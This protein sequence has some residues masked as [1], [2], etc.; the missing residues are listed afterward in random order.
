M[1]KTRGWALF[2]ILSGIGLS[3]LWACSL[4]RKVPGG[5]VDFQAVYLA[6]QTLIRHHNPYSVAE[7]A[8]TFSAMGGD[9]LHFPDPYYYRQLLI[10]FVN[11]PTT[12]LVVAPLA[13]L[14]MATAQALWMI[15]EIASLALAAFL[16][17]DLGAARAPVLCACLAGFLMLNC[18][19]VLAAGN[20]AALVI[21]LSV[22]AAWCFFEE[23]FVAAGVVCMALAL[24]IKP[25]DSGFVWLFF[26]LAGG[27]LR[28]RALQSAV[29]AACVAIPALL[30]VGHVAPTWLHDWQS[31]LAVISAPGALNDPRPTSVTANSSAAVIGLQATFSI[32]DSNAQFF[33]LASYLVCAPLVIVWIVTTLRA[34]LDREKF[35]FAL[36]AIV[37]VTLLITYHRVYDAKLL[38]L[39]IPACAVLWNSAGRIRWVA[40]LLSWVALVINSDV[41][42]T[43]IHILADYL[44]L[45]TAT[46][47]GKI[48]TAVVANPNQEIL[49]ALAIFYL[50]VYVKRSQVDPARESVSPAME[51]TQ[52]MPAA[53]AQT[54]L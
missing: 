21:P 29:V 37:P 13:L 48:L 28:K 33:N 5:P 44:H 41:P 38:L 39:V 34:R 51:E 17:W 52:G 8:S 47:S 54:V 27:R 46:L 40:L 7:M 45:S 6:S 11:L 24:C 3:T 32:F 43:V 23:R 9:H 30:W 42:I 53:S 36:A 26:L 2:L 1:N 31:N 10:L 50:W 18:E 20:T 4:A 16:M 22:I 25:H 15:L 12:L 35:Y 14:P 49:L 19:A